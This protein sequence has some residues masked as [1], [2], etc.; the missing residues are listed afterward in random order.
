MRLIRDFEPGGK[1]VAALGTFDGVH[2]AHQELLRQGR[3]FADAAGCP[4]RVYTF[5]RHPLEVLRPE[6]AP[7]IL[8]T[9][10]EQMARMEKAGV[11]E[12][13]ILSFTR[14]TADMPPE[15]FLR[16]L[17]EENSLAAVVAGWNYTFGRRGQGNAETLRRDGEKHGYRVII[18]PSVTTDTGEIISSTAIREKLGRGDLSGAEK[19][20]GYDYT[21]SGPVVNGKH[22]GTRIGFPTANIRTNPRKLLPAYGVYAA[23]MRCGEKS[24][25]AVVNI[26]LQPTIPS[27]AV[28]VEAHAI[29]A[30][31]D[32][33][34]E[35]AAVELKARL[36]G[37]IRFGSVEEL[38]AQIERDRAEAL[39]RM[40][41]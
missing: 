24:W 12:L 19:M 1:R 8:T 28:T 7:R 32:F 15:D 10:E 4:L 26:G 37:E 23:R 18:V 34:G 30:S 25:P 5:D 17:R 6:K 22:Q 9:R 35:V 27:G 36:R 13:R 41:G 40:G 11:E 29:G 21:L 20:L 14:E 31:G 39:R 38:K 3:A 16:L 33:Y 2:R